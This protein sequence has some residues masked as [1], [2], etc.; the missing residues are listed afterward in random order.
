MFESDCFKNDSS[1][2][3]GCW[4]LLDNHLSLA[5]H[6]NSSP[7]VW[8]K[9][10]W[11]RF[12]PRILHVLSSITVFFYPEKLQSLMST[13]IPITWCSHHYAWYGEWYLVM[14]FIGFVPNITF[15]P[16]HNMVIV[17]FHILCSIT[18]GTCCKQD[19]CFGIFVFSRLPSFQYV[20]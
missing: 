10:I 16:K 11:T 5:K 17:L 20:I 8:W 6:V 9:A 14:C 3:F 12:P 4:S 7:S 2:Q 1:C 19:A 18:L 13:S 15:C